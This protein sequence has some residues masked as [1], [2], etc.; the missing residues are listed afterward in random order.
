MVGWVCDLR[1][2]AH[3]KISEDGGKCQWK[4]NSENEPFSVVWLIFRLLSGKVDVNLPQA[5]Q[6]IMKLQD[7]NYHLF[8]DYEIENRTWIKTIGIPAI[9]VLGS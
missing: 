2:D 8:I 5:N 1:Y 9:Y 7:F 3:G 4:F 6:D